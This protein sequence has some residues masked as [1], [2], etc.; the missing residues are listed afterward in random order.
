[1][2]DRPDEPWRDETLLREIELLGEVIAAATASPGR[3]TWRQIDEFLGVVAV[4][5]VTAVPD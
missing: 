2:G 1:M 5:G 3:L 4:G